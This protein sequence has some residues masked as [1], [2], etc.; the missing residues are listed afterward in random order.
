M[1]LTLNEE[2]NLPRALQSVAGWAA[3]IFVVDSGSTDRTLEIA[4]S[5]NAHVVQHPFENQAAQFNWALDHLSLVTDWILR[6]DADEYLTEE[7]KAEIDET[8]GQVTSEITG[9]EIKRRVYFLGRWI[10]HGGYYPTWLMRLFRRGQG[11]Y[12]DRLVDEHLVLSSG[13]A[14]RLDQDL[15]DDN[16]KGLSDWIQKHNVYASREAEASRRASAPLAGQAG[17]KRWLKTR[18][19][20]RSP[21]FVRALAYY[22]YRYIVRLGFLDGKEGLVFH[23]LQAG[24]YRFLVDAKILEG[25]LS[26][27]G[28]DGIDQR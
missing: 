25:L 28:R 4:R 24:W 9:F 6:L 13:R 21:L 12:E 20:D 22:L 1:I 11:R 15:I 23:F 5:F 2:R 19:Y 8:L 17:Q 26:S 27:H 14:G 10:K 16:Q 7:L 3:E 18:L